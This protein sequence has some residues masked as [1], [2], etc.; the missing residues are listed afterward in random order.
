MQNLFVKKYWDEEDVLFYLH[1]QN[2]EAVRQIEMTPK[3]KV[4]LTL[5]NPRQGG[6]YAI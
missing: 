5:E 2:G 6:V 4:F 3:G 1:F